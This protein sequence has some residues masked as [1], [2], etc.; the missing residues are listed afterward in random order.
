MAEPLRPASAGRPWRRA[1]APRSNEVRHGGTLPDSDQDLARLTGVSLLVVGAENEAV[2]V[3]ASL[4]Q[5]LVTPIVVRHRGEPL[6][7]SAFPPF[8]TFVIHG[9]ETLTREEQDGLHDWLS[10]GNGRAR[11]V[12]AASESLFAMVESGVFND[13]LYYRL[14]VVTIDLTSPVLS[15][16][17]D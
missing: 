13:A 3:I 10:A 8:G 6:Q 16:P 4:W 15:H 11:V 12:S 7:L 17:H 2:A 1:F 5:G 9:V 14:N